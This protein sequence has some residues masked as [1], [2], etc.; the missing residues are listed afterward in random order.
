MTRE[1][2]LLRR[3]AIRA[4]QGQT[5][6]LVVIA[7]PLFLALIA[8]VS[9]GS[10]LFANKRSV[11]N[12]ADASVLAA[13]RE[14]NPDLSL[15]TGPASTVGTCLNRIETTA[16]DYSQRNNGSNPLHGCANAADWDCYQTPFPGASDYGGLQVR[17]KRNVPLSFGGVVGLS[18]SSVTATAAASLGL[19]SGAANVSPVAVQLDIARCTMPT[20]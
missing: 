11:Q 9:D 3:K 15:C 14:F 6:I 13:V 18:S 20:A 7:L 4:E 1:R 5:L 17:L 10:N 2:D 19:P 16:S 12:A 8:L